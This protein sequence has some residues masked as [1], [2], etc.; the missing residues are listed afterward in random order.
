M[1]VTFDDV[2]R[3]LGEKKKVGAEGCRWAPRVPAGAPEGSPE[4]AGGRSCGHS[5]RC[6][7]TIEDFS[8]VKMVAARASGTLMASRLKQN[9]FLF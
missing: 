2:S 6:A 5:C 1:W 4:S 9:K 3:P 8:R 7:K